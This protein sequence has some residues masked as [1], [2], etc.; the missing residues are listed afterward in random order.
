MVDPIIII[1]IIILLV[2][3]IALFIFGNY[4][5]KIVFS[6]SNDLG[7]EIKEID[8]SFKES[9]FFA[10]THKELLI[11]N[12]IKKK[13]YKK[14]QFKTLTI[15][16][17]DNLTLYANYLDNNSDI[18]II[19]VH[20]YKSNPIGDFCAIIEMYLERNYNVLLLENRGHCRSEGKYIGFSE[21]DRFDIKSWVEIIHKLNPNMKVFLHGVSMGA[22]SVIHSADMD[23]DVKGIIADCGFTSILDITK[24][25]I[26]DMYG[27]PYFPF[28]ELARL[29]AYLF[30]KVS[31]NKSNSKEIVKHTNIP[32]A[33]ISGKDDGFVP[34]KMTIDT[35]N[36][37]ISKKYLLLV[38]GAGHAASYMKNSEAYKNIVY[39]LIDE[40]KG[41]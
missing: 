35:Y 34:A 39:Q 26:K 30:N 16:S 2:L 40:N 4:L 6:R 36:N 22:S 13:E 37:C 20:G 21:L 15:K 5:F 23:L 12:N 1:L 18:T 14:L 28:G 11:Y 19:C 32:I 3:L 41:E 29:N 7:E 17:Y 9:P 25:L 31:F 8:N 38:D 24:H 33:F 27:L 10:P